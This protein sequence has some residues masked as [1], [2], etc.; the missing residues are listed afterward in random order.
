MTAGTR[1]TVFAAVWDPGGGMTEVLRDWA[2]RAGAR[3]R[4]RAG[5]VAFFDVAPDAATLHQ[6]SD[7]R[8]TGL[9]LGELFNLEAL[10]DELA[11]AGVPAGPE[12]AAILAAGYATWSADLFAR[13]EGTFALALWDERQ[14]ELVLYRDGS[15]A[16]GL[17]WHRGDGWGAAATRLDLLASLPGVPKAVAPRGLHE[18]LRFLDV[19]PPA[20]ILAGI[21]A[22]EPGLPTRPAAAELRDATAPRPGAGPDARGPAHRPTPSFDACVDALDR[23][24]HDSI[25]RRLDRAGP[26]GVFLSGGIDSSMICAIAAR[27]DRD[28]VEAFTLGF[29]ESG[30]DERPIATAVAAHLGVRHH[31]V[32]GDMADYAAAFEDFAAGI[33]LPFA[34]PAGLPT[35][36]LFQA[37]RK[38]AAVALD[39][40]GADTLLGVMPARHTRIAT[41]YAALLPRRLRHGLAA[42]LRHVPGAAGY[43]PLLG[44]D[45]PEDVLIRWRGWSRAEIEALCGTPVD[46]GDTRFFRVYR[47]FAR[48]EHFARYSALLANLPDDRIH[49][50]AELTGLRVRFPYWD[51]GVEQLV[52]GLPVHYRYTTTEPK[53]L[54]RAVLE[55]HVPR[56]LWDVPKHGFDFPF[57]AFLQH[58]GFALM[59]RYLDDDSLA[60][61]RLVAR[62]EVAPYVGAFRGGDRRLGFRSW[63]LVVLSAWL[64]HHHAGL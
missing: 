20:T 59:R 44:F 8:S 51:G 9:L 12:P 24:L 2:A 17:Y 50:A 5:P 35:L 28:A 53:R 27:I 38:V 63:A 30:F 54:L 62:D 60:I 52:K 36:R 56:H 15:A 33:D 42:L 61:Y 25:A 45:A 48:S 29:A 13:L 6:W 39:G 31:A 34:D 58:D 64:E 21:D 23:V 55:R 1:P 47:Q 41:Q 7:D 11:R 49:Q 37:C 26:T 3:L 19:S 14:H 4:A 22:I 16:R 46:F 32:T 10:R 40:T 57:V 18:Y 43:L